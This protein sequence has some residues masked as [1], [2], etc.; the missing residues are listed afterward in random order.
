MK[1]IYFL[2][3][4]CSLTF[5]LNAKSFNID[6]IILTGKVIDNETKDPL[7]YAT[8]VVKSS[9]NK[10][11]T[12][13]ITN[14]NGDFEIQVARGTYN[15]SVEFISFKSKFFN[16][17]QI[18]GNTDLGIIALDIDAESLDE[19]EIIA[20][21]STV[22]I[23]LDKKIYNV[24][25]DMTVKGGNASDVLDNVPSVAVDVE[26]NVSLRGNENV[27]ILINGKPSGL[28]GLNSTDALRQLPA[29]A[30]E[31]VEVITSPSARYEA[32]GTAGILNIILR[33]GKAQGFNG[34]LNT[35]VGNPDNFRASIN[36]NYRTKKANFFNNIG[37]NYRNAPGNSINNTTYFDEI[38]SIS[39][40]RNESRIYDRENNNFNSRFGIEYFLNDKTSITGTILYRKSNGDDIATNSINILDK[41]NILTRDNERIE[42]E[43]EDDETIQYSLNFSKNFKKEGHKLMFDFQ[44]GK[45]TENSFAYITDFDSFPVSI[46]NNPERNSTNEESKDV[47]VKG[48]Y[49]LP[50]SE[51]AQFEFGFRAD[52]NNLYTDYLVEDF[53]TNTNDFFNNTNFSNTLDFQQDIYALYSQY[54]E[55]IDKFSYLLGLRMETTDRKINLIQTNEV[56]NRKFTE[57]FP[58]INLGLEFNDTESITLGYSRRL[59]R[60]RSWFLNPFENRT[61]ETFVRTGNA[62]LDPTFTNS[63]E[64]GYL[65]RWNKLILNSSIY[66][67]HAINNIDM[68]QTEDIRNIDGEQTVVIIRSPINLS[69]QDRYG[70]EFTTNY[71]P[72]KWWKLTNSFNFFKFAT[73][74]DYE[75]ISFDAENLSWFTRLVSRINLPGKIDWQTTGFYRGRSEGAQS[76]R[77]GMLSVNLAFSKDVLKENGT[78]SLNVSDLFNSR[79]RQSTSFSPTTE[80]YGEFQW[81]QRQVLLN[82]TYRFNQKKK[83]GR[84]QGDYRENGDDEMFKA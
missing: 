80:T 72:F 32:E 61:S 78:I 2:L 60:P 26:G 83:R 15:I 50:L 11:I 69:S 54:G 20:E 81:R 10:I 44:Y 17:T 18:L 13:G 75:G 52:L 77:K 21:K 31:K 49:V 3:L 53:D 14:S 8:I 55:K 4:L 40:Y 5:S 62:N 43:S 47:L 67:Q 51:N 25:K 7:E 33:K 57:F 9:D 42:S 24:G 63:F 82:F 65:K 41:N 1:K 27:R 73:K 74:G 36:V 38:G 12:G 28:V 79:K 37:Y 22:E 35:T 70:F 84:S 6:K 19:V 58:T 23:R 48:D 29:D 64:L 16:N 56:F 30:I 39:S 76:I 59:R 66:Y 46:E 34:S 71:T 45:S 68:V